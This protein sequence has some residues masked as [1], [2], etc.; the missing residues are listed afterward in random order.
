MATLK[1]IDL[2]GK[3]HLVQAETGE[4]VIHAGMSNLVPG[5]VSDCGGNCACAS[6]HVYVDP[7]W[8]DRLAPAQP[9]EVDMLTCVL[10]QKAT[11]RLSCQIKMRP[12]LDGLVVHVV[13]NQF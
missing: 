12:E 6:C 1:F 4:S 9:V 10:E 13:K 11:S 7:E 8:V 3:E 5:L 2:G